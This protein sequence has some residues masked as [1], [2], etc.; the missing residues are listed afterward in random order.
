MKLSNYKIKTRKKIL[1]IPIETKSRELQSR[2]LIALFAIQEG[3]HVIL[4]R[5][6]VVENIAIEIDDGVLL[7]KSNV[8]K[9]FANSNILLT[10][11]D[12]EGV[13][14]NN[15]EALKK[16][17]FSSDEPLN[18][19]RFIAGERQ[20]NIL[21]DWFIEK[22]E[23]AVIIGEPRFDLLGL[24]K[25]N[26]NYRNQ[27][28][29]E[30]LKPYIFVPTS[31]AKVN[32]RIQNTGKSDYIEHLMA[33]EE[34]QLMD[35]TNLK[36]EL[37]YLKNVFYSFMEMIKVLALEYDNY[38]IVVRPHP[39]EDL[40]RWVRSF[41]GLHN[42]VIDQ[43]GNS[44]DWV[45]N[46]SLVIFNRSTVGLESILLN[47][48][49]I[50]YLPNYSDY[51]SECITEKI[52]VQVNTLDELLVEVSKVIEGKQKTLSLDKDMDLISKYIK[53]SKNFASHLLINYLI[54]HISFD[55]NT[56]ITR[57]VIRASNKV[58]KLKS[59]IILNF[60]KA[61]FVFDKI[62]YR[63]LHLMPFYSISSRIQKLP[64]IQKTE[65]IKIMNSQ[66]KLISS[67]KSTENIKV[68]KI[69]LDT[70]LLRQDS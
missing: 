39:D 64:S 3:F 43:S 47:K 46:S 14:F 5:K 48:D 40:L 52:G 41:R 15:I 42:V 22:D 36:H 65:V 59:I 33:K 54:D 30:K 38:N 31:L 11:N 69:G 29:M 57:L 10:I 58:K 35:Y 50:N 61:I 12:V 16:R 6:A 7:S 67:Q 1:Y 63:I 56:E 34:N 23:N 21:K 68:I 49:T 20:Y 4:G 17:F 27:S 13:V 28:R 8:G 26:L 37:S 55:N 70:F 45:I 18:E 60:Y 25:N 9:R 2:I 66:I 62:S 32:L 24:Y 19:I 51:C 44:T 53:L